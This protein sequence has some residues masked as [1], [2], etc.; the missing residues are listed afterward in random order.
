VPII[1][2]YGNAVSHGRTEQSSGCR[3]AQVD[4]GEIDRSRAHARSRAHVHARVR[5]Q[6]REITLPCVGGFFATAAGWT[7]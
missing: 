6:G 4:C 3:S 1:S 5:C 7:C 2:A